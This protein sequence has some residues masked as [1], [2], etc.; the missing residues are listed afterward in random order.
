MLLDGDR[1]YIVQTL[2]TVLMTHVQRPSMKDCETV[3]RSLIST[4]SFL[5][6]DEG[7]GEVCDTIDFFITRN[8]YSTCALLLETVT[9][10]IQGSQ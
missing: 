2:A 4:H 6:D 8:N 5:K 10:T 3:A 9:I 7:D 1:R